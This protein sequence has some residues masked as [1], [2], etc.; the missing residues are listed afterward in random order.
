MWTIFGEPR[1]GIHSIRIFDIAIVDL[2]LT[3]LLAYYIP[4]EERYIY[5][6]AIW[7]IIGLI[8]HRIFGIE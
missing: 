5:S 7:L 6:L 3:M 2:L 8:L 4:L 1:K